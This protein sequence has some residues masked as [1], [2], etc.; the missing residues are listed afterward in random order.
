MD[1]NSV[2]R[3]CQA[4]AA[5]TSDPAPGPLYIRPELNSGGKAP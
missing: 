4:V 1:C 5:A 2:A 3:L